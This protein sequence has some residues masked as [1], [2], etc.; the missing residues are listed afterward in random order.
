[1]ETSIEIRE[2]IEA[3]NW[4]WNIQKSFF[5]II[6]KKG[7]V[8]I[9]ENSLEYGFDSDLGRDDRQKALATYPQYIFLTNFFLNL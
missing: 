6:S 5:C 8:E 9:F 1:M 7:I 4:P 3:M 2:T